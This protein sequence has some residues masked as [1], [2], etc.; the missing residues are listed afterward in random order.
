MTV[1]IYPGVSV[2]Q[3]QQIRAVITG[4]LTGIAARFSRW[5]AGSYPH[6]A[7]VIFT[8][9]W[10]DRPR[11]VAG[12]ADFIDKVTVDELRPLRE[13]LGSAATFTGEAALG[14]ARR[15][16]WPCDPSQTLS[17]IVPRRS[18]SATR[19]LDSRK[20]P[21]ETPSV[22]QVRMPAKW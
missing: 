20:L 4:P 9:K 2:D 6:E 11:K 12:A 7:M 10:T 3:W 8:A 21:R 16:S 18:R 19:R 14:G 5:L 1:D 22:P 17:A 15:L 13:S